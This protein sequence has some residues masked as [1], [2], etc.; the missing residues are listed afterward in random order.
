MSLHDLFANKLH[1]LAGL[2]KLLIAG[3][4]PLVKASKD[5]ELQAAFTEH[6][7]QTEKQAT[8]ITDAVSSLR[9]ESK[10][11][12]CKPMVAMVADAAKAALTEPEGVIRDLAMLGA[13]ERVEH[14]EIAAYS[15]AISLAKTLGYG[16]AANLLVENLLEEQKAAEH[17]KKISKTLL[18]R[19]QE[20]A[21]Q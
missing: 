14:F 11:D 12:A 2:E 18:K 10:T 15:S 3:L 1:E 7:K 16:D 6:L 19:A 17:L 21:R 4:P 5:A 20:E 8:R 9:L 13:A